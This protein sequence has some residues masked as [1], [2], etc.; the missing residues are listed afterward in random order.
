[1]FPPG[2]NL[3][4]GVINM[5]DDCT[6]NVDLIYPDENI[7]DS[8]E[9]INNNFTNLK[10]AVCDVEG[11][12]DRIVNIR[13]F[14]YYGPNSVS[15]QENTSSRPNDATIEAFVNDSDKL[16]LARE[17]I[18]ETGDIAYVI[19]QK[20]GWYS[21]QD[22]YYRSGTGSLPFQRT[23]RVAVTRRIGIGGCF[24]E[25]TLVQTPTGKKSIK[26]IKQGDT[27]YSFDPVTKTKVA[28]K[29]IK[30]HF[31]ASKD[32]LPLLEILHENGSLKV[33]ENHW[34]YTDKKGYKEAKEFKKGDYLV[35][36]LQGTK[37][38]I[39]KINKN[40]KYDYV[41]NLTVEK[42]HNF[43]ANDVCVGDF[44]ID[45]VTQV[46][47]DIPSLAFEIYE[48]ESPKWEV[49]NS[50]LQTGAL[51]KYEQV[52]TRFITT[53]PKLKKIIQKITNIFVNKQIKTE[54]MFVS[55]SKGPINIK[56]LK[57]GDNVYSYNYKNLSL[58]EQNITSITKLSDVNSYK[59][60][61][62]Y[63]EIT[64]PTSQLI[65][66]DG[67]YKK[68]SSLKVGDKLTF[69]E[70]SFVYK[71][72]FSR[73]SKVLKIERVKKTGYELEV[74]GAHNYIA[75]GIFVHNGK[76]G[77]GG[78][79]TTY[80][81]RV[82]T[83]YVGYRWETNVSDTYR[84]Y[85]PTLVIYRLTYNGTQYLMDSG[86]PKFTQASTSSTTNWNNPQLWTTY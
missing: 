1:M 84:A 76:G 38:K 81:P 45:E 46:Q 13:T 59:I 26:D 11:T 67:K 75:N 24:T 55:T 39:L 69:L 16:N 35:T 43:Y 8:L 62:E 54:N 32:N 71:T 66:L 65:L 68:V 78:T 7:G 48:N 42:Y 77:G 79:V 6:V 56:N 57:I 72:Q 10:Q 47:N 3:N 36:D 5:A 17:N 49:L 20:T 33:I 83:Y 73:L 50:W 41:Y 70:N 74:S 18:S 29:V 25:D 28:A 21:K 34:L 37:S 51:K 60:V 86:F 61:H 2:I 14:F 22:S 12:L 15:G 52:L 44:E 23:V 80:E 4:Y 63:G 9:K 19:Y 82:E 30:C 27:V 40:V 58:E 31:F 85:A 64:L 53:K